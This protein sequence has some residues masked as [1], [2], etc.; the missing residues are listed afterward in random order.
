M[1]RK[2][3]LEKIAQVICVDRQNLYGQPENSFTTT[4]QLWATYLDARLVKAPEGTTHIQALQPHDIAAM[5]MLLKVA[6]IAANPQNTDSWVDAAGYAACG[7]E[8]AP[9]VEAQAEMQFAA[10]SSNSAPPKESCNP[11]NK[12]DDSVLTRDQI[13]LAH[14]ISRMLDRQGVPR[15]DF[16]L[17]VI[18]K[19]RHTASR[20]TMVEFANLIRLIF[21]L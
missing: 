1:H 21:S 11:A 5:M 20:L 18:K 10:G 12:H 4:A 7:A 3:I 6:R 9:Q 14:T 8:V 2:E 17:A 16:E 13:G 15:P 19:A